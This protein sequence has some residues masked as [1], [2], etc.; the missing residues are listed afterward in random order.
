MS[1]MG[2]LLIFLGICLLVAG[3]VF[4]VFDKIPGFGRL[5]GDILLKRK[6]FTVYFPI[7]TCVVISMVITI[8][9]WLSN[10]R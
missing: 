2:K 7:M 9:L 5:P 10:K 1:D 3:V 6:N 4:L 8:I